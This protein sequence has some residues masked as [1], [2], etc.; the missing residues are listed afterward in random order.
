[1]IQNFV[2]IAMI[3]MEIR[4]NL[5]RKYNFSRLFEQFIA[6]ANFGTIYQND[7]K[8]GNIPFFKFLLEL[9]R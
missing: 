1:M 6:P 3:L 2:N 4:V 7:T 9:C 5:Q 8:N